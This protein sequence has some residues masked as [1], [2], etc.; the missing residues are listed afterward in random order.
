[1]NQENRPRGRAFA[2]GPDNPVKHRYLP[3]KSNN[4]LASLLDENTESKEV[5]EAGDQAYPIE[6]EKVQG[7]SL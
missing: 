2:K 1:V 6:Q 5:S 4:S 3:K 7:R